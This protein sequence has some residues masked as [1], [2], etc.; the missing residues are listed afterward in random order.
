MPPCT[1][2]SRFQPYS[3]RS[4]VLNVFLM[5][6]FGEAHTPTLHSACFRIVA[7]RGYTKA[8]HIRTLV[9]ILGILVEVYTSNTRGLQD[10]TS[11]VGSAQNNAN[12]IIR[13]AVSRCPRV[14]RVPEH[15]SD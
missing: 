1:P 5:F 6:S 11:A 13:R 9:K 12:T 14:K 10:F 7:R 2:V 4:L 8:H 15:V 3:T